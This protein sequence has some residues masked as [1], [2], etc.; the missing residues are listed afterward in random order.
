MQRQIACPF[1]SKAVRSPCD[2]TERQEVLGPLAPPVSEVR[3]PNLCGVG[4]CIDPACL[5][6]RRL[7]PAA[8]R[9]GQSPPSRWTRPGMQMDPPP[10][11]VLA[12]AHAVRCI[13][14]S[15]GAQQSGCITAPKS[16]TSILKGRKKTLTVPLRACVRLVT[17]L[18]PRATGSN[19]CGYPR[20]SCLFIEQF[21]GRP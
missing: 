8:A 6:G 1:F 20:P 10:L 11:S 19:C 15:P 7:L 2:R 9:Q 17:R 21:P 5:L 12:G 4:R 18:R 14:L 13:H 3:A 16:C